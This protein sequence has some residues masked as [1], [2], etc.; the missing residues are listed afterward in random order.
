MIY[1]YF[2]KIVRCSLYGEKND[3]I[4]SVG[5]ARNTKKIAIICGKNCN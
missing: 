4:V 2:Y 5:Y 3:T 1:K